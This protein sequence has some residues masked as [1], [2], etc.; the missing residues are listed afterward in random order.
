[1]DEESQSDAMDEEAT[2][3]GIEESEEGLVAVKMDDGRP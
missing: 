3:V 2:N 1:M